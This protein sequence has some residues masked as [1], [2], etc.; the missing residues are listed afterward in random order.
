MRAAEA[1]GRTPGRRAQPA[2]P[3]STYTPPPPLTPAELEARRLERE[4]E[5][6]AVNECIARAR[7]AAEHAKAEIELHAATYESELGDLALWRTDDF[8]SRRTAEL[9]ELRRD[10]AFL[11]LVGLT[12]DGVRDALTDL[13]F[14]SL[15]LLLPRVG[16]KAIIVGMRQSFGV[17]ALAYCLAARDTILRT[18]RLEFE[19]VVGSGNADVFASNFERA[20]YRV[21]CGGDSFPRDIPCDWVMAQDELPASVPVTGS[22]PWPVE[23]QL[24]WFRRYNYDGACRCPTCVIPRL[25]PDI[26]SGL[27]GRNQRGLTRSFY[28]DS[29]ASELWA[30]H[31]VPEAPAGTIGY[32]VYTWHP[33]MVC[34]FPPDN[35][36]TSG[37]EG[38]A[39]RDGGFPRRQ[40]M[41]W[42]WTPGDAERNRGGVRV[43]KFN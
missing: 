1:D 8:T 3:R 27:K 32:P 37:R 18:L 26:T 36:A 17:G 7:A 35:P 22:A 13:L 41:L 16:A 28:K 19:H 21:I 40:P 2:R 39:M 12:A 29:G 38:A 15:A 20:A 30:V 25:G 34:A 33:C 43:I 24:P 9:D 11:D 5:V 14:R 42:L 23:G 31:G 10:T 4:R 6:H